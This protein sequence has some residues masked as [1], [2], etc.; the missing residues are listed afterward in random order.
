MP[1]VMSDS[2]ASTCSMRRSS[3]ESARIWSSATTLA[4]SDTAISSSFLSAS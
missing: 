3:R 1:M 2:R 4:G